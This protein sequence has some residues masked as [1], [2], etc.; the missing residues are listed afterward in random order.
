MS[1][2]RQDFAFPFRVDPVSQQTAQAA[3]AAHVDQ[4]VQQLLLTTPGERVDLPQFGCGLRA[5][6]FAAGSD[7]LEA[8]V[9]LRVIQALGQWLD[10]IVTVL[11]VALGAAPGTVIEP[12]TVE[13]TVTYTLVETQARPDRDGDG[14]MSA[15]TTIDRRRLLSASDALNGIDFVEVADDGLSLT[16][17]FL[18]GVDLA[19]ARVP[20][21]DR[22]PAARSIAAVAVLPI[23]D[24]AWTADSESRLVLTLDRRPARGLL[25]LQLVIDSTAL[26]PFFDHAAFR[27][28][29]DCP[30]PGCDRAG[31][32]P[33]GP[34]DARPIDYLAKD[35]T[36]LPSGPVGLLRACA[37]RTGSSARRPT[38]A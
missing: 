2:A 31:T 12:G 21:G 23:P 22:S 27:F 5:L 33:A 14:L 38:S 34:A 4:M 28:Q 20:R 17:H 37:T 1:I 29:G 30:P 10:G 16:V 35:F 9:K 8:T 18:N 36:Q 26:D 25:D 11:D 3:Y 6:V 19:A 15:L 24:A 13:V 7:A 32:G